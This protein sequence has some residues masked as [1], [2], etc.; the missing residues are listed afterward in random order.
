MTKKGLGKGLQALIPSGPLLDRKSEDQVLLLPIEDI[1]PNANQPRK[2]FDPDKIRELAESIAEH[3]IVQPIVVRPVSEGR[4]QI[5]VGE[6]RWRAGKLAGRT[7][8]PCIVKDFDEKT[9][10]ELALI[11][12]IQR[13]NLNSLEEAEAYQRLLVEFNYTQE[14]LAARLGKSRSYVANTLRLLNLAGPVQGFIREGVLTAGHARAILSL[15]VPEKRLVF[16]EKIIKDKLSVRQAEELAK[17][18]N[19]QHMAPATDKVKQEHPPKK[20]D[21]PL[22]LVIRDVENRLRSLLG[23]RVK[24]RPAEKGGRIEIDY[25]GEEDLERIASTLLPDDTF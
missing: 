5:V 7:E 20:P 8:I 22:P 11:E 6:R 24:I 12:N 23:T 9:V 19:A 18:I 2:N 1:L 25:Y 14:S 13:E 3:G 16:A 4:Y 17:E 15:D 10:T 21:P